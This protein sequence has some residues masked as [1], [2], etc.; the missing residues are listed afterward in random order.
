[1]LGRNGF[2][3]SFTSVP[4]A[5]SRSTMD[6]EPS[7]CASSNA[8]RWDTPGSSGGPSRS[9]SGWMPRLRLDRPMLISLPANGKCRSGQ[10]GGKLMPDA[11]GPSTAITESKYVRSAVTV[12]VHVASS[13]TRS[14][15]TGGTAS[16]ATGSGGAGEEDGGAA[17]GLGG[18]ADSESCPHSSQKRPASAAPHAWH[19][20]PAAGSSASAV[21]GASAT[22]TAAP[23][24]SRPQTSQNSS[25]VE[26]WPCGQ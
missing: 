14:A 25:S 1:M 23:P 10:Y 24:I 8:C 3:S 11:S 26:V 18:G 21:A 20:V 15:G 17:T 22:V 9:M 6:H 19:V 16:S 4:F 12:A 13:G 2:G 5:E 7:A